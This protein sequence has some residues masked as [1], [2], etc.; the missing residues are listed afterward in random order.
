MGLDITK[1]IGALSA[2]IA[3]VGGS[4]SLADKV[5][6]LEKD[7]LRWSP[8]HFQISNGKAD[9]E[10]KV[11]VAREKLRNDCDVIGFKLEVRDSEF[12]V[13]PA[14][15]SIAIFSGPASPTVEKL[16]Y[17]FR[18][19]PDHLHKVAPGRATLLAHIKYKC[20][21]GEVLVNYPSHQNLTFWIEG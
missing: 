13:H 10:F 7:I 18:I 2:T 6:W 12:F 8:E 3:V 21:E 16:G 9:S 1:T 20:P 5:G 15:P 11:V 4:Y 17:M 14:K 19:D